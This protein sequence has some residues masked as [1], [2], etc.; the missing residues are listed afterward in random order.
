M[1]GLNLDKL[2]DVQET[3]NKRGSGSGKNWVTLSKIGEEPLD[4]RILDPLATMDGIYFVEVPVYWINGERLI[5][6]KLLDPNSKDVID[7]IL[8][9]AKADAKTDKTLAKLLNAKDEKTDMPKIQFKWD[10]WVPILQFAWDYDAKTKNLKGIFNADLT[11]NVELIRNFIVDGRVKILQANITSL[12]AIN[13]LLT[14]RGG[15]NMLD[16]AKGKNIQ[17]QKTG[18]GR[19]TKYAVV[20]MEEMPMPADFY[21]EEKMTD[22]YEIAQALMMTDEYMAAVIENYLYGDVEIP[23]KDDNFRYPE[24]REKLKDRTQ[25]E[26]PQE[27]KAS[28]RRGG[29]PTPSSTS[30]RGTVPPNTFQEE[31]AP[32]RGRVATPP[33]V[34]NDDLATAPPAA[35]P[36]RRGRPAAAPARGGRRNLADDLKN[37]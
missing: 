34:A 30:G 20:P 25:E 6:P 37:A 27:E 2:K 14:S 12:K 19:D 8:D 21:T 28:R 35:P 23:N 22:P 26:E 33:V 5:S 7:Q 16:A 13:T 18:K 17:I 31:A 9:Q 24:I 29:A 10:Y 1:S 3:L 11:Y 32:V 15:A 4:C 36:V